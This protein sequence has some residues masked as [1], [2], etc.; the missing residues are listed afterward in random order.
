MGLNFVVLE[1][2]SDVGG[3][4][5]WNT[6]PGVACDIPSYLYSY[7][8]FPSNTW[9]NT[10]PGGAQMHRYLKRFYNFARLEEYTKFNTEVTKAIWNELSKRWEI[11][12]RC[13]NHETT[14]DYNWLIS[15]VG[16][17]HQPS[18]PK[19]KNAKSFKGVT[20][21]TAFWDHNVNLEGKRIGIIGS[22]SSAVQ[23]LPEL[24]KDSKCENIVQFQRTPPYVIPRLGVTY[25][26]IFNKLM[27]LVS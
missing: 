12:T 9:T 2:G 26:K 17:L 27:E 3:T 24:I 18:Y 21:H 5:Y 15:C 16:G 13:E 20:F 8:N 14:T 10:F 19:F 4:W 22:G 7:S 25:P 1:K 6:Y 11:T 23:V